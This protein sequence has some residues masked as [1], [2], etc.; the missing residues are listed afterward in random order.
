MPFDGR[1]FKQQ[2]D[3]VLV[4]LRQARERVAQ[5]YGWTQGVAEYNGKVCTIGAI[6]FFIP[7]M[8]TH[9]I[10][11]E[12]LA[13][14]LPAEHYPDLDASCRLISYN[15]APGRTQAEIVALYDRA[16]ALREQELRV[17]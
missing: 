10:A 2:Q 3:E 5:P 7:D 16:I 4:L 11:S 8:G 6:E 12:A 14:Q 13:K 15:D 17:E 9:L 1:N